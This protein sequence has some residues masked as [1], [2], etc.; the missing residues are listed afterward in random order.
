MD[1]QNP[2]LGRIA[3]AC[4][5]SFAAGAALG[6]EPNPYYVGASQEFVRDSNFFRVAPDQVATRQTVSS[7]SLLAGLDQ[8]IGRHRLFA[9]A[10]LRS[11]RHDGN[12]QLDYTGNSLLAGADWSAIDVLSGRLTYGTERKLARYGVDYGFV[13]PN[14]R[15]LQTSKELVFKAQYGQASVLAV[16]GG[17]TRQEIDFS[18][19]S[20]NQFEQD[21]F[22][23]GVKL[24]P[25]G[26]LTLGLAARRTDGSYPFAS[27]GGGVV[28]ADDYERND[29]DLSGVWAATGASTLSARLSYT[30]EDHAALPARNVSGTTGAVA[31]KYQPTGKLKLGLDWIRDTG[32]TSSFNA[33]AAGGVTPIVNSSPLATTWQLQAEYEVLAKVQ[34]QALARE[35]KRHLINTAGETGGDKLVETVLGVNWAPLRSV[36][37]GCSVGR[38]KRDADASGLSTSY[39]ATVTRCLA[40]L[41]LQ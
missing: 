34:L 38:E 15:V 3:S 22:M 14:T 1:S 27:L 5:L 9:D 20:S 7:T 25:S 19:Q 35:Y 37:V 39:S 4:L 6:Q 36:Q 12:G 41:R 17:Y 16:E 31:W 18:V 21:T 11:V 29:I 30:K 10:A 33:G 28:G 26:P 8:P 2:R 40:Q 13:D 32:A 23:A 24:W